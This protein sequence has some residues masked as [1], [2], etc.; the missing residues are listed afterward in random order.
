MIAFVLVDLGQR[1]DRVNV[2]LNAAAPFVS[3]L[4]D[5]N[6][7]SFTAYCVSANRLDTL[8]AAARENDDVLALAT[9]LLADSGK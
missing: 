8:T 4:E 9:A 7:F 5:P 3:K 2:A 1:V 6:G